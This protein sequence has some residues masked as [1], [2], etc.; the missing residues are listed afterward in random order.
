MPKER[1]FAVVLWL[2]LNEKA[3]A[4]MAKIAQ[5]EPVEPFESTEYE[6]MK[7]FHWKFDELREAENFLSSLKALSE[8]P[9]IVV[10]RLTNYDD[11]RIT[12][13]DSRQTTH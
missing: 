4:L 2:R 7:D 13:K 6:G 12:L 5:L 11:V 9:E 10:L 3:E 1:I 8:A